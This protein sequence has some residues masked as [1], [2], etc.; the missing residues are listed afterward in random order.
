MLRGIANVRLVWR[1]ARTLFRHDALFPREYLA[2]LPPSLRT[3]RRMLGARR[4]SNELAP[5]GVRLARALES[6]G[7]PYIKL[8]QILATRPDVVG[9]EHAASTSARPR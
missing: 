6:L 3:A 5:P 1:A 7:P 9:S 2:V 4:G 8:G